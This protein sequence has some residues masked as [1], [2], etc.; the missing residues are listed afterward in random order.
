MSQVTPFD[1]IYALVLGGILEEGITM[2]KCRSGRFYL[3]FAFGGFPFI[4]LIFALKKV[5]A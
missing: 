5:I 3:P 2:K 4:S 1:F